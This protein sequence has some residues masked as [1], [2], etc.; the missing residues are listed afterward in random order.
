MGEEELLGWNWQ[1]ER[2]GRQEQSPCRPQVSKMSWGLFEAGKSEWALWIG[3][4][5]PVRQRIWGKRRGKGWL[6]RSGQVVGLGKGMAGKE[7]VCLGEL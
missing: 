4:K 6:T 7:Y 3:T 2:N 5:W 1:R